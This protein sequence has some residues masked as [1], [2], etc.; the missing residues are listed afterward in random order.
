[1]VQGILDAQ[2]KPAKRRVRRSLPRVAVVG[3][4]AALVLS[5]GAGAAVAYNKLASESFAGVFGTAHT[6]IV[7]KIGR[8]VGASATAGGVTVTA[9]AIIGDKYHYA[10]TYSIAKDDGTAFDIDLSKTVGDGLLPLTFGQEDSFLAGYMGGEHGGSYFYDADPDDNAIQ[11]VTMR[12]ISNG[13]I[14]HRAVKAKFSD[15]CVFD[16]DMNRQVIAEGKWSLKF[17]LNFE[18]ASASLPA[19]QTFELNGMT[20]TIDEITLSPIALRVDYTVDSELQWED[21]PSGRETD[22]NAAQSK[23]YFED[24]SIV[25]TKTDG[26]T[27]DLTYAG[28]S[29]APEN[30]KTVCQKG[31]LFSE[32]VPLDEIASLT[33]GG[34]EIPLR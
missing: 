32:V 26:T 15:L 13:E 19:G 28:G 24:V 10:I 30:G 3:V 17:D 31:D 2:A 21:A 27:L 29:I 22:Y 6:E 8:P 33:V 25:L 16:E 11:Y 1:M 18:D 9:D 23:K 5:I 4:A 20:A 34:I 7:D 14:K 12:E